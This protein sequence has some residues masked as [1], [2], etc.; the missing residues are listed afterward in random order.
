MFSGDVTLRG[1]QATIVWGYHTAAV[2]TGWRVQRTAQGSWTF[3]AQLQRGDAFIL[4]QR[5]LQFTVSRPG[6][7]FVWPVVT[8]VTVG[9]TLS[10][11]LGP[12]EQ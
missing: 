10:G 6:G 4:R 2:C 1:P 12:P 8:L 9:Q 11:V 3:A 7:Y 5:P